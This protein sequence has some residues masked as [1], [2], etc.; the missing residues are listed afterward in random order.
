M[1]LCNTIFFIFNIHNYLLKRSVL[2]SEMKNAFPYSL[3]LFIFEEK[4]LLL[5]S[6][7]L[8]GHAHTIE[9]KY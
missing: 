8:F 3:N 1:N 9:K 2:L 5:F 4:I 7:T 6:E